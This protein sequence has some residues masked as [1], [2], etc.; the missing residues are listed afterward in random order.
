MNAILW[1]ALVIGA[2]ALQVLR[3]AAQRDLTGR[4]GIWGAAYIR[5]FYGLPFAYLWTAAIVSWRGMSGDASFEFF[6]WTALGAVTQVSA[7]A[8]LVLAMTGRAFAVATA[9][10][11]TEVMGAALLGALFI[12]D[13]LSLADWAGA[14]IGTA[15]VVAMAHVSANRSALRAALAGAGS[16]LLYAVSA[17][18]YR[19]AAHAWGEDGWIGAAMTLSVTLTIQTLGGGLVLLII[20]RHEFVALLRAWRLSIIPGAAG[21]TASALLFTAFA[22]GPS[23][24]A[25]KT[26]Q[27]I[28]VIFAWLVSR[29]L[30]REG[31]ALNEIV[32]AALILIGALAVLLL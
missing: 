10:S 31:I 29:R 1:P 30:Y 19:A 25:V 28:D 26:V 22:L 4:L 24:A 18:S 27:L 17:I 12:Q 5:F 11:K 13:T 6:A 23:A 32:G 16:G 14:A 21:A 3:N 8:M 2:A 7:T 20:A 15:G 9:L